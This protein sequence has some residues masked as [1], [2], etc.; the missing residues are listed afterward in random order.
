QTAS[1][2]G[3]RGND[4]LLPR[5]PLRRKDRPHRVSKRVHAAQRP[6]CRRA[7]QPGLRDQGA[8]RRSAGCL[9]VRHGSRGDRPAV[10]LKWV[11]H[12]SKETQMNTLHILT[13]SHPMSASSPVLEVEGATIRFGKFTAVDEVSLSVAPGEVFGLLGPNGSGK[14]TLIRALCGLLPL[15]TGTAQVLGRDVARY[16]EEIRSQIGHMSQK[17]SLY[18][19]LSAD[20]NMTFYAGI[21]GLTNG[22]ARGRKEELV[23]LT[24]LG[25]YL[26][27]RAAR[28][29][30]GWKQ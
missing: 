16:A 28:L 29:S 7:T 10:A 19:D 17:F 30:G 2:T 3:C 20:E 18:S 27:Q 6:E 24:G 9:Q 14:T 21:Y 11:M 15:P 25:P 8:R 22:E 13:G 5:P 26:G 4:G 12:R 23:A 1:G